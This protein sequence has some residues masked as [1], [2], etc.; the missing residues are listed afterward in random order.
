MCSHNT[1][2]EDLVHAHWLKM[3]L[4]ISCEVVWLI[5]WRCGCLLV[6]RWCGSLVGDV[7]AHLLG[8]FLSH[9]VEM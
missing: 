1:V 9:W 4:L 2:V 3:W 6:V 5:C 8:D 7:M